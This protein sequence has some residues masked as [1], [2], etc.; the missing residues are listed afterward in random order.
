MKLEDSDDLYASQH[1]L[2]TLIFECRPSA[3]DS[4][5][6][7]LPKLQAPTFD[8]K[9][10]NWMSFWEQFDVAIHSRPTLSDVDKLAYLRNALKDGSAKGIMEGLSASG[11]FY[12]EAIDTLKARYDRP[13]LIYQSHVCVILEAPGLKEETGR[14]IR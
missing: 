13:R 8:G 9:F 14:E 7:R 2:E 12:A 5:G 3:S 6:V 11:E 10:T 1:R 4:K